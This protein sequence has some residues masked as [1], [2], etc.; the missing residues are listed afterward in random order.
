MW[1][2]TEK[3]VVR[4]DGNKLLTFTTSDGL[5]DNECFDIFE[6]SRH[7]IWFAT[8]NGEPTFYQNGVFYSKKNCSFL[9]NHTFKGPALKVLEDRN[10]TIF[11]MTFF[12]IFKLD[13]QNKLSPVKI[14]GLGFSALSLNSK[15]EVLA[16]GNNSKKQ[17]TIFNLSN[18]QQK[19]S[20]NKNETCQITS[21]SFLA[22]D[23]LYFS[24]RNYIHINQLNTGKFRKQKILSEEEG[25]VIQFITKRD[26][27][28][29]F[30]TNNGIIITDLKGTRK[31]IFPNNSVS[32]IYVDREKN[33]WISTVNHGVFLILNT[34]IQVFDEGGDLTN[35]KCQSIVR[36][37]NGKIGVGY[38]AFKFATIDQQG[39]HSI[40]L[41]PYI[42]VGSVKKI[43][44][45]DEHYYVAA[46]TSITKLNKNYKLVNEIFYPCKDI[47]IQSKDEIYTVG[48][49]GLCKFSME[50][51]F[52]KNK[53]KELNNKILQGLIKANG[54][55]RT[56]KKELYVY[57][58]F[59]VLK[60][61]N[62]SFHNIHPS[63]YLAKNIMDIA[64]DQYG[65]Q[66]FA[67]SVHG[68]IALYKNRVYQFG[69]NQGLTTDY[70]SSLSIGKNNEI[71]LGTTKGLSKVNYS[72]EKGRIVVRF[73]NYNRS[74][75]LNNNMINELLYDR[76]TLWLATSNGIC[77]FNQHHLDVTKAPPLLNIEHLFVSGEEKPFSKKIILDPNQNNIRVSFKGLSYASLGNITYMYRLLGSNSKWNYTSLT[78]IEYPSLQS[79]DYSLEIK[80]I[81]AFG[82][83]SPISKIDFKIIPYFYQSWW[84][85][86]LTIAILAFLLYLLIT[87]RI[88]KIK[89]NHSLKEQIFKLE[90]ERLKSEHKETVLLKE[91]YELEQKA[92]L[93]QMNPHFI[94]NSINS[95]Q[96]LYKR[97]RE[98]ADEYLIK[99]SNLLR[100]ILEFSR[101]KIISL[102][103]EIGFL[104]NYMEINKLRMKN[105]F[106]VHINIDPGLNPQSIAIA[107]MIIQPFVEN[108]L[109][110]GIHALKKEGEITLNFYP[111][112]NH[113]ICEI[114]DNG[115][116]RA[117]S[118]QINQNRIHQSVGMDITE[119]RL[120][121]FNKNSSHNSME[122]IDLLDSQNH[123]AGTKVILEMNMEEFY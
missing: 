115:V 96:G 57:G 86:V 54:L 90:H 25:Q 99:F 42:G 39:I 36:L 88:K 103:Q 41:K 7:R 44:Y 32:C 48:G 18:P 34:D 78:K 107:P 46:G 64:E 112:S 89:L 1:F 83:Q 110:H 9:R 75:G 13:A 2:A 21:K 85:L 73:K 120:N 29:W 49:F 101:K 105:D 61:H 35:N 5:A 62:K 72:F 30:G 84:F 65:I 33:T 17:S 55:F 19:P 91:Y 74:N 40:S 31:T 121:F 80:A 24:L 20:T 12:G 113:L 68:L 28:F 87:Y 119:K 6:D 14:D 69:M 104:K 4:Y 23:V 122:I 76:D 79:G 71:W 97:N 45:F 123:A 15:G 77:F 82:N 58:L 27:N 92:L 60:Y 47:L 98:Q 106:K 22:N 38:E 37:E 66:W 11:Y 16:V 8:F 43:I 50:N 116:G 56:K 81:D 52:V 117:R 102:D 94:F 67:S 70:V 93:L 111:K 26:G 53:S 118:K 100:Q 108:A 109:L 10:K 114:V 95:I 51:L 63:P 3:G 59:G